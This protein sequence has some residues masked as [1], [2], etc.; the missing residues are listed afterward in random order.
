MIVLFSI[1]LG[2]VLFMIGVFRLF[3]SITNYSFHQTASEILEWL[4]SPNFIKAF[5][6]LILGM[7]L[8]IG[9]ISIMMP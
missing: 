3:L 8:M 7:V 1:M 5:I 2:I 6:C 4:L 9:P